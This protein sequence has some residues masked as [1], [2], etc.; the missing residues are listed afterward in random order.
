MHDVVTTTRSRAVARRR[1]ATLIAV[2]ATLACVA[3]SKPGSY[4]PLEPRLA[5]E[6]AITMQPRRGEDTAG[7]A[8]RGKSSMRT[9][10]RR[11][12]GG[13]EV[14]PQS[15]E[16]G[17]GFATIF[18]LEDKE[19][20]HV[21][22]TQGPNEP[23]PNFKA[24]SFDLR[25]PLVAGRTWDDTSESLFLRQPVEVTGES[26]IEAV[27]D[28]VTVPAG[29]YKKCVRVRFTTLD[30]DVPASLGGGSLKIS[31]V[32]WFAPGVGMVKYQQ[33]DR[34]SAGSGTLTA[35]LQ[36]FKQL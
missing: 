14:T 30:G 19:G 24:D 36:S 21:V 11:E 29:T 9:M 22:A 13:R 7:P 20:V 34:S 26:L 15:I 6:Y 23:G 18:R 27:D 25:Y 35:E 10:A 16:L 3:C 8:Q 33:D 5:W 1:G 32:R 2:A 31:S 28:V 4:F 17:G 12:L